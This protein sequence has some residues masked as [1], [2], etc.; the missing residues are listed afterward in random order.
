MGFKGY[1]DGLEWV[2]CGVCGLRFNRLEIVHHRGL[3]TDAERRRLKEEYEKGVR[4]A[5]KIR[6]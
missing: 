4:D 1:L 5:Y 6:G 3:H 2:K